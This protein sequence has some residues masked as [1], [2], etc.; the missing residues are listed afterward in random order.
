M[1]GPLFKQITVIAPG[2]LGGSLAMAC[3]ERGLAAT[4]MG[5]ARRQET[6][7]LGL[8][9][10]AFDHVTR[11]LPEGV[12]GAEL[13][14]IGAPVRASISILQSIVPHIPKACIV[15]DVGSTKQAIMDAALEVLPPGRF[16]GGH[17]MAGSHE[18]GMEA[19]DPALFVGARYLLTEDGQTPRC[20]LDRVEAL[21]RALGAEPLWMDARDHDRLTARISHLPHVAACALVECAA[22][23]ELSGVDALALASTGFRDTTRVAAGHP[24]MW[25]DICLTNRAGLLEALDAYQSAL[26]LLR[27]RISEAEEAEIKDWLE[28]AAAVR[29]GMGQ[30]N[31]RETE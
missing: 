12:R 6:L 7:D 10:G 28:S 1:A 13:V 23:F 11:D 26:A 4:V 16:V 19:A 18:S 25:T 15:T 9:R 27:T 29:R 20:T 8:R 24:T 14:V 5:V 17:P 3:R 31:D 22:N 30:P 2:L 21:V